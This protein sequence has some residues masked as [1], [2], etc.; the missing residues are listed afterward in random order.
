MDSVRAKLAKL[1]RLDQISV[2]W[3]DA[4]QSSNVSISGKIPNH[5]VETSVISN[6]RFLGLQEGETFHELHLII[7]KDSSDRHRGTVQSIPI[8]LIKQ[9][10][11]FGKLP[12]L[13]RKKG[14][15]K[16]STFRIRYS[17]GIT[18]TVKI[19]ERNAI[20]VTA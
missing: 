16:S 4:S 8:V 1:N 6:G 17:D 13:F 15:T 3:I 5:A 11:L 2:A 18:K 7:L 19:P 12:L 10:E 14:S 20:Q 9:L